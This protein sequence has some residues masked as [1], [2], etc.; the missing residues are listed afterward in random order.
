MGFRSHKA[1]H[2]KSL[3]PVQRVAKI[4]ASRAAAIFFVF[5]HF[6]FFI[7]RKILSIFRKKCKNEKKSLPSHLFEPPGR[8]TRNRIIFMDSLTWFISVSSIYDNN[9]YVIL[10]IIDMM[11][12]SRFISWRRHHVDNQQNEICSCTY[13][14]FVTWTSYFW[15][16]LFLSHVQ[17]KF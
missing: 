15:Y 13:Q 10:L 5:F 8:S 16:K 12:S 4:E 1:V 9:L 6:F 7:C 3:F 2:K 14:T 11:P 17:R